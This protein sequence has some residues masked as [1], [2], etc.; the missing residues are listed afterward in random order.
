MLEL[1]KSLKY[2][3]NKIVEQLLYYIR[4]I[5]EVRKINDQPK[6]LQG[7]LNIVRYVDFIN[8]CRIILKIYYTIKRDCRIFRIRE[9]IGLAG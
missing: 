4:A 2:R 6:T 5:R 7:M 1:F 8:D 3:D 9:R